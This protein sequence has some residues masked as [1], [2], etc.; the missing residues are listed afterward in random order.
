M[1]F[2]T[3]ETQ[4]DKAFAVSVTTDNLHF[5]ADEPATAGGD[6]LGPSPYDLLLAALGS[7]TVMTLH[8]YARR[9]EWPLESVHVNLSFDRVH[10]EDAAAVESTAK[11][12]ERI[13]REITLRGPLTDQQR[14][15]LL[16]I[17]ARCPVHRTLTGDPQIVDALVE[18]SARAV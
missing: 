14:Q 6:S 12:V 4:P 2:V 11:R 1:A 18:E 7:C 10:E 5:T 13:T 15:R 8:L 9:K 17:A 3:V 16:E